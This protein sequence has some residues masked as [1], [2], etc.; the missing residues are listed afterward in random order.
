MSSHP[1]ECV[2]DGSVPTQISSS[3]G[4]TIIIPQALSSL[5]DSLETL[6]LSTRF[7]PPH[8]ASPKDVLEV[9]QANYVD[10]IEL[11][12]NNN[13]DEREL[14]TA[15]FELRARAMGITGEKFVA[16]KVA[17]WEGMWVAKQNGDDIGVS[18][19]YSAPFA[20][21]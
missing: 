8:N 20:R 19:L 16:Q 18:T 4:K 12:E 21:L 11:V 1:H 10:I 13:A 15:E 6:P 5:S 14:R 17:I 7:N 3:E 2:P 9:G